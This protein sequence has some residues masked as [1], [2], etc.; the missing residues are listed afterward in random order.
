MIGPVE[1]HHVFNGESV[2]TVLSSFNVEISAALSG[3]AYDKN[4]IVSDGG[5]FRSAENQI[6]WNQQTNAELASVGAGESGSVSFNLTPK[7]TGSTGTPIIN[8]IVSIVANVSGDR[9]GDVSGTITSAATRNLRVSPTVSLSGRV[10][11]TTGSI[12]NSGPIPPKVDQ[13]TTYTIVWN[14]DNTS[15]P[16][17]GAVVTAKLPPNVKWTGQI[18]PSFE[19][20]SY[21]PNSSVITWNAGSVG[22]YTRAAGKTKEVSFQVSIE[23]NLP[24]AGQAPELISSASLSANDDFSGTKLGD[25]QDALTTRFSTDPGFRQGDEIVVK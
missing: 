25:T 7:G 10:V 5:Y 20:I 16:V 4:G 1:C 17:T 12:S 23:P 21:E 18:S 13:K 22:T 19:D 9:V 3:N 14:I 24:Q 11:R 2:L 6:I 8:P 15:S